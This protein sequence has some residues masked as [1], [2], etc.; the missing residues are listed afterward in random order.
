[1]GLRPHE[2]P[3]AARGAPL[4]IIPVRRTAERYCR[5]FSDSAASRSALV[6]ILW[7]A[8]LS[9]VGFPKRMTSRSPRSLSCT[10]F[11]GFSKGVARIFPEVRPTFSTSSSPPTLFHPKSQHF[12]KVPL[13]KVGLTVCKP[14]HF[15]CLWNDTT[16]KKLY[17]AGKRGT[18]NKHLS[19]RS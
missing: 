5:R 7:K 16:S 18:L 1:M 3:R 14:K 15:W 10:V 12:V 6:N 17:I 11:T 8:L 4:K 13:L 19:G 2:A 9:S